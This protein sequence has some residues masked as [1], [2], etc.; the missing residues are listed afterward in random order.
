MEGPRG[1][2]A[3]HVERV[4]ALCGSLFTVFNEE[5]D[6]TSPTLDPEP[7]QTSAMPII[8]KEPD[9]TADCE[10]ITKTMPG[11]MTE[12]IFVLELEPHRESD[13]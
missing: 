4:L 3:Q 10:P 1:S 12:A 7:S 5:E 13:L 8:D 6:T 2:F 11:D 9:P